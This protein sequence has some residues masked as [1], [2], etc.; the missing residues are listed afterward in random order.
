MSALGTSLHGGAA[1]SAGKGEGCHEHKHV[2]ASHKIPQSQSESKASMHENYQ[3][4]EKNLSVQQ[5]MGR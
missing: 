5:F 4:L 3:V 1:A 2:Q